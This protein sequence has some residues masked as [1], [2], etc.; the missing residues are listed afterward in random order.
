MVF[1]AAHRRRC[2]SDDYNRHN[3]HH[4]VA[5]AIHGAACMLSISGWLPMKPYVDLCHGENDDGSLGEYRV[6]ISTDPEVKDE[7]IDSKLASEVK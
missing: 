6:L 1:R 4:D 2:K 7:L 3:D 5:T